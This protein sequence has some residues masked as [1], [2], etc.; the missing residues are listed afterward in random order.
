M[1]RWLSSIT[2]INPAIYADAASYANNGY[3]FICQGGTTTQLVYLWEIM[4]GGQAAAA[5]AMIMIMGRD[6]TVGTGT[7]SQG[8]GQANAPSHPSS[9]ALGSPPLVGN[10]FATA[11]PVRSAAAHLMNFSFN[12]YGGLAFWRANRIEECKAV[13]GSAQ[14]L[15]EISISAFTGSTAS[16]PIGGHMEYEPL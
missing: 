10:N 15:G 7:N 3:P 14:P 9:V 4:M 1:A 6:S 11:Q 13:L 8:T 12:A 16:T 5:A 2:T